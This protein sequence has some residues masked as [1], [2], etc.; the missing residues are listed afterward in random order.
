MNLFELYA[1]LDEA[2][3]L[4]YKAKNNESEL[5][6]E[7]LQIAKDLIWQIKYKVEKEVKK[8]ETNG[9]EDRETTALAT[10][11]TETVE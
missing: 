6:R 9:S 1:K 4:L 2:E 5:S 11:G 3:M 10:E 7:Y 8:E